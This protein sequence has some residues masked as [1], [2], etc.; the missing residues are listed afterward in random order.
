MRLSSKQPG[1]VVSLLLAISL[2]TGSF[3]STTA[4]ARAKAPTGKLASQ[5][6]VSE[7][8]SAPSD[9]ESYSGDGD[10]EFENGS[11]RPTFPKHLPERPKAFLPPMMFE[12]RVK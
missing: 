5:F 7:P 11:S 4:F 10:D 2:L 9:V 3:A 6:A 8:N 1:K 12:I